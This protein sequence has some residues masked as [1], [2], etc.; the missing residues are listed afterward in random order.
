[1]LLC[2]RYISNKIFVGF[3]AFVAILVILIWFSRAIIF[4]NYVTE[5]GIELSKFFYL[6]ILI[7][8]WILLF[9][10]PVA[11]FAGILIIYNR[12]IATNEITILKNSGLTKLAICKPAIPAVIVASIVCFIVSFYL[13]P[14]ANRELKLS[15]ID[16]QNNYANLSFNPKT[17]E[18]LKNLTI[19]AKDRDENNRLYGILLHDERSDKYSITITAQSGNINSTSNASLL[20]MENGTI[21]KYHYL[22]DTTEILHFDNYVFNLTEG[23]KDS[24]QVKWN[25]KERYFNELLFPEGGVSDENLARFRSEINKRITRPFSPIILALIALS[26]ILSGKFS[27][28]GNYKNIIKAITVGVAFTLITL[29]CY[30]LI[31][32]SIKYTAFLYIN[33]LMFL[34]ITLWSLTANYRKKR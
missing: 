19:Y 13:M 21:Q 8:P 24:S 31:E 18:T 2:N 14:F 32:R 29:L 22:K 9:I 20:Y 3:G 12:L 5:N 11:I 17:F 6:F 30:D 15:R 4:V 25:A 23:K 7:L 1:M 33:Y 16:F 28:H 10:V 34:V 27:R 26:S